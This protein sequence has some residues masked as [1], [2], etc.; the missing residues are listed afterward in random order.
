ML[1]V[2][3][4][5]GGPK[6]GLV[7][8][9][10]A[11]AW[12][13]HRPVET[14]V[15][16][17]GGATQDS[18]EWWEAILDL[19]RDAVRAGVVDP[20]SIV[21][22]SCTG[23]Y[24]ST[25][26]VD[27]EGAPTGDCILWMDSRARD[28]ARARFGGPV[29]GYAPRDLAAFV[30]AS[31]GAPSLSGADPIGQRLLLQ[32]RLPEVVARSRWLIEPI[33]QLTLRFCG[34]AVATP[35][36][37][38]TSWLLDTRRPDHV[39]YDDDLILRAGVDRRLLP[40]L[41]PIGSVAGTLRPD[42]ASRLGLGDDVAVVTAAP[43]L[44]TA[45]LGS[46]AVHPHRAHLALS[47]SSWISCPIGR[48]QTDLRRQITTVPGLTSGEYL[49]IDNHEVGGLAL[50]WWLDRRREVDPTVDFATLEA[51]ASSARPGSGGVIFTPWLNGERS[52]VDDRNARGG[53]TNV[54]LTSTRADLTRSVYEGVALNSRWLFDAVEHLTGRHLEPIRMI[55][56][57]AE[58]DLWCQLHAD[59]LDRV[60]ERPAQPRQANLRGAGLHA[61]LALGVRT[62]DDVARRV[63]VDAT[64]RPQPASRAALARAYEVFPDLHARQRQIF[65]H[66]NDPAW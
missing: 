62:L 31:G 43:D 45:A 46:G 33:D 26:P 36:T 61:A 22:V 2:D 41:K 19:G 25:V 13:G 56:G 52:P 30:R 57:G 44:H 63:E 10:G 23:Q 28:L 65:R 55:G 53:F 51:E 15:T 27:A 17:D 18:D 1:A 7:D 60:V 21:A 4:G 8:F 47:T 3:L 20:A 58:S 14:R 37:M 39:A 64:F 12:R 50:A 42:L 16:A 48:K 34:T 32:E 29:A 54:S 49:V 24:A 59:A 66:L 5:T 11:I 9:D 38:A 6:V 35:A 40:P